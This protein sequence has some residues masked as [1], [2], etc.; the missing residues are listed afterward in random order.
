M[1]AR[2]QTLVLLAPVVEYEVL[3]SCMC[4]SLS[5]GIIFGLK[6][7]IFRLYVLLWFLCDV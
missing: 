6:E 7:L 2:W 3:C 4:P 5:V 1:L